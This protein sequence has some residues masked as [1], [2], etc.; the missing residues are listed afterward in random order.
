MR[1]LQFE[2]QVIVSIRLNAFGELFSAGE[3]FNSQSLSV[4]LMVSLERSLKATRSKAACQNDSSGIHVAPAP[5]RSA[6]RNTMATAA[7]ARLTSQTT[8]A[9]AVA[10]VLEYSLYIGGLSFQERAYS[11]LKGDF[12]PKIVALSKS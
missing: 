10:I 4:T 7:I 6:A 8:M 9:I 3:P 12:R 1:I 11:K 2:K 5:R